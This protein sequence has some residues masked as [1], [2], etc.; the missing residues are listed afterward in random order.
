MSFFTING[1][2]QLAIYA[3]FMSLIFSLLTTFSLIVAVWA[4]RND[5][6]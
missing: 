2:N 6:F 5:V 3:L 4:I 1:P